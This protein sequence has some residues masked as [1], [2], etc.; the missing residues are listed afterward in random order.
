[1]CHWRLYIAW[2]GPKDYVLCRWL[3]DYGWFGFTG[4]VR[5]F[6]LLVQVYDKRADA[7]HDD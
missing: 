7:G 4:Y 1:M 3:L 6:G 5:V 2:S